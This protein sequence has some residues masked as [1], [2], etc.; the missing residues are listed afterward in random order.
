MFDVL[1]CQYGYVLYIFG[2]FSVKV[3]QGYVVDCSDDSDLIFIKLCW[4]VLQG[5]REFW[6]GLICSMCYIL[7]ISYQGIQLIVYGGQIMGDFVGFQL[8][9]FGVLQSICV[10]IV[11]FECFVCKVFGVDGLVS[12]YNDVNKVCLQVVLDVII[13]CLCDGL[14][15]NLLYDFEFGLGCLDVIGLIFNLVGYEL[16]V[17]EQIYGV[18][19]VFVSYLFLWNVLQLDCVQ[20]IG[21]NL[22]YINVVDIDNCKF[23]VGVLVCNV[24]EVVGV[25]VDVKVFSLIQ[26][27]LYIGYL[28]SINVD[29][30][31]CIEDQ[32]G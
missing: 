2:G 23:D 21:F 1:I 10:D 24:G 14:Y 32:F 30:L 6:V 3:V 20:W 28:L 8:E 15:F 11:K 17:D 4:K 5:F 9:I 16:Y 26:L 22:N 13:V 12:G 25:F 31:I 29:N 27:V 18:E 7:Y 19:D